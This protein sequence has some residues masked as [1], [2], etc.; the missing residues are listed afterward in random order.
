MTAKKPAAPKIGMNTVK[1]SNVQAHGYD[2]V[3]R[4]LA[5]QFKGKDGKPG[6]LHHYHNVQ[7]ATVASMHKAESVG[8]FLNA[9]VKSKHDSTKIGD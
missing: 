5:V 9:H 6:A 8:V 2:P 4:T 1:S 3:T 7:P